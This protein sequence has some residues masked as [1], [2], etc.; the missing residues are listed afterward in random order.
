M[1]AAIAL[2]CAPFFAR[3]VQV[4][5]EPSFH[6]IWHDEFQK[7]GL[8]D[9]AKWGNEV[10]KIRNN[11]LQY[12][13]KARLANEFVSDGH[14]T[15]EAIHEPFKGAE[16]TSASLTTHKKF[17]FEYGRL[18][19]RAKL[20]A[21][22][23]TWPAVWMMGEDRD[24]VG[25]PRCGE[26]DVMEHVAFQPEK[27]FGTVHMPKPDGTP[28]YSQGG[29]AICPTCSSA[30]HVYR[31]DWSPKALEFYVDDHLYFTY[32]YQG[33][34]KWVFDRPMYLILNLAVGGTWG[35]SHGVD[36]TV[37]PQKYEISYVRVW[38]KDK[39]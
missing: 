11:E 4:P 30:F 15:I 26:I 18:E 13:T 8:P 20:P 19:V 29:N 24:Q 21:G 36:S 5:D 1:I 3:A 35:G 16:Y 28:H 9:P 31:L 25:W 27:I 10:G 39:K 17:S 14:L 33:P 34:A 32:P 6:L 2:M 12:Y 38:Q 37:F 23:G 7:N 22:S